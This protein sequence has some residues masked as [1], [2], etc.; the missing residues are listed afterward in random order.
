MIDAIDVVA[1]GAHP[2]DVEIGCGGALLLAVAS[3]L[4]TAIVDCTAGERSTRGDATTRLVEREEASRLLGVAHRECLGLP[5]TQLA[6]TPDNRDSLVDMVRRLR[7]RVVLAPLP[8]D[9]HPDHAAVGRLVRSVCFL[10]GVAA[11]GSGAV[12]RPSSVFHYLLHHTI[13]PSFVLDV[14]P[15]WD[16]KWQ[17]IHAYTSQFLEPDGDDDGTQLSDGSFLGAVAARSVAA[18]A[19]VGVARGEP[20]WCPGP[21]GMEHLPSLTVNTSSYRAFL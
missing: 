6:D 17:A 1:V 20:Y 18:G 15:V 16:R 7:P 21:L 11:V 5:D 9:R 12:H 14:T 8:E 2:D 19:M 13:Q 3:G 4:S 10:S